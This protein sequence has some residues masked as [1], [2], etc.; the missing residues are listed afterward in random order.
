MRYPRCGDHHAL[1]RCRQQR[2]V[3]GDA[4]RRSKGQGLG[5]GDAHLAGDGTWVAVRRLSQS[6]HRPHV[7]DFEEGAGRTAQRLRAIRSQPAQR[8]DRACRRRD[9][10]SVR[11]ASRCVPRFVRHRSPREL[12]EGVQAH[13]TRRCRLRTDGGLHDRKA[14][15]A[16]GRQGGAHGRGAPSD[17][18]VARFRRERIRCAGATLAGQCARPALA[19][20]RCTRHRARRTWTSRFLRRHNIPLEPPESFQ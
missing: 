14:P 20:A 5:G 2:G 12:P 11:P 10:S 7:R 19:S 18:G 4:R 3:D 6:H 1:G 17:A 16:A 8:S 15:V 13:A 9:R